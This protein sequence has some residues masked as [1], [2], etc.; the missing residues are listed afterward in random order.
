MRV[1]SEVSQR[2]S[3][4]RNTMNQQK[5]YVRVHLVLSPIQCNHCQGWNTSPTDDLFVYA[6]I[7]ACSN[8]YTSWCYT[9]LEENAPAFLMQAMLHI[10]TKHC[11]IP[12]INGS[13]MRHG[14]IIF[15]F[16]VLWLP[17]NLCLQWDRKPPFCTL[18]LQ[19]QVTWFHNHQNVINENY[20]LLLPTLVFM[21]VIFSR[22]YTFFFIHLIYLICSSICDMIKFNIFLQLSFH[23][24]WLKV[25]YMFCLYCQIFSP[26]HTQL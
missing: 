25:I 6:W 11:I 9:V 23:L 21:P 16:K 14:M 12:T 18:L 20:C 26:I 8:L 2:W 17:C 24:S 19:F 7:Q 10:I 4:K 3:V 5:L 22:W 1:Y 13:S 15:I